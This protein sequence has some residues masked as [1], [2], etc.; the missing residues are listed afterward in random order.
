MAELPAPE[1]FAAAAQP[2]REDDVA[3]QVPCGP[4]VS[5]CHHC[6]HAT[7]S[8]RDGDLWILTLPCPRTHLKCLTAFVT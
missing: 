8:E 4:D 3:S 6:E 2:V 1:H 5:R 7:T